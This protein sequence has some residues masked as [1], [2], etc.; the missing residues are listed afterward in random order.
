MLAFIPTVRVAMKASKSE[1]ERLAALKAKRDQLQARIAQLQAREHT[2]K[3]SQRNRALALLGVILEA[4]LVN[5]ESPDIVP[6]AGAAEKLLKAHDAEF[7]KAWLKESFG[8]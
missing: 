4:E 7:L 8:A 2:K 5:S 1:E 3:R 6:L